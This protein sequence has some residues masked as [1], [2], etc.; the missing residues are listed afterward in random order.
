M[1]ATDSATVGVNGT[2]DAHKEPAAVMVHKSAKGPTIGTT[3]GTAV[4]F[5]ATSS[6]S[7]KGDIFSSQQY[8]SGTKVEL[9]SGGNGSRSA[10]Y[11]LAVLAPSADAV[12]AYL[13]N[14]PPGARLLIK[15]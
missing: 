10:T 5:M 4:V 14:R 12:M 9:L 7:G 2:S 15:D 6:G 3:T 8:T 13:A 1:S 11:S